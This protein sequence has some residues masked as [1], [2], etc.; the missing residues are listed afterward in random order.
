MQV[1]SDWLLPMRAAV[2]KKQFNSMI[3]YYCQDI[4]GAKYQGPMAPGA[5][6]YQDSGA[7]GPQCQLPVVNGSQCST[8]SQQR[9]MLYIFISDDIASMHRYL[10]M[11]SAHVDIQLDCSIQVGTYIVLV[12]GVRYVNVECKVQF[13]H[14]CLSPY[15]GCLHESLYHILSSFYLLNTYLYII[16]IQ[17]WRMLGF[18]GSSHLPL[19]LE[20]LIVKQHHQFH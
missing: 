10:T 5:N 13:W 2:Y 3:P 16:L 1:S 12:I 18:G 17:S 7:N 4:L 14:C 6:Q 9:S 20:R 19:L 15:H 11:S 8:S